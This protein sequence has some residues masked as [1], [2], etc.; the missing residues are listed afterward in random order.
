MYK[1]NQQTQWNSF[2]SFFLMLLNIKKHRK[3]FLHKIFYRNKQSGNF[4]F[5]LRIFNIK[6]G[7]LLE[8]K[9]DFASICNYWLQSL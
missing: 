9:Y 5:N 2:D 7:S 6:L 1:I 8:K 4:F 3:L